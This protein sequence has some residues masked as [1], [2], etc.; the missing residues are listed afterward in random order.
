MTDPRLAPP[1]YEGLIAAFVLA[2]VGASE[3]SAG[4]RPAG[5]AVAESWARRLAASARGRAVPRVS[6]LPGSLMSTGDAAVVLGLSAH[7]VAEL[8][9]SGQLDGER[10]GGR[11]L[12]SRHDVALM[13]AERRAAVM[14]GKRKSGRVET[15]VPRG[16]HRLQSAE[17]AM[18]RHQ[19]T[20]DPGGP[21]PTKVNVRRGLA[22][23]H[24]KAKDT[25]AA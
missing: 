1:G 20:S 2:A 8:V 15:S 23:G 16:Q 13:A 12:V 18:D 3:R 19:D 5:A 7:R 9:R 11:W 22:P 6:W 25:D 10:T 14:A 17:A 4:G 24:P 21:G